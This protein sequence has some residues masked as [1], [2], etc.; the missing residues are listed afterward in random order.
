MI[1]GPGKELNFQ[2]RLDILFQVAL[3]IKDLHAIDISPKSLPSIEYEVLNIKGAIH[4]D[5]KPENILIFPE[6]DGRHI[7]KVIDFGYSTLFSSDEDPVVMPYSGVWTAPE[8]HHRGISPEQARKMD[9][10]SFGMLCSWLLFHNINSNRDRSIKRFRENSS[11]ESSAYASEMLKESPHLEHWE[12]VN[13][14]RLFRSTLAENPADRTA[15]F[16]EVLEIISP[17]RSAQPLCSK[18]N[19]K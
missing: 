4:G 16:I 18:Y 15:C 1:S 5:I 6:G 19:I 13:M 2:D 8:Y 9:V 7:A 3:A 10:Y 12:I 14:E 11:T 17:Q